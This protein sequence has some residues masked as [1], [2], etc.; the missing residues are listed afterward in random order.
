[1]KAVDYLFYKIYRL[2]NFFGN[3][4]FYPEANTWF[5][6]FSLIGLNL[7]T[8]LNIVELKVGGSVISTELVVIL[9]VLYILA[10]YVYFL[11]GNRYKKIIEKFSNET[12]TKKK[13]GS[14]IVAIYVLMTLVAYYYTAGQLRAMAL[15]WHE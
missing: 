10:T 4:D 1:M 14:V 8:I 5:L 12:G 13:W 2:I 6:S 7:L 9:L 3:T 11:K 15:R